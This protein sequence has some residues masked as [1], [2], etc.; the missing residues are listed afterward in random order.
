[1]EDR[2][3]LKRLTGR[4]QSGGPEE[5]CPWYVWDSTRR[6]VCSPDPSHAAKGPTWPHAG[7]HP[8]SRDGPSLTA[9][10]TSVT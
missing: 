8:L 10:L 9:A 7:A 6:A 1:M 2:L 3:V 4:E 5:T